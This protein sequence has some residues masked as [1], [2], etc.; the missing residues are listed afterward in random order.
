MRSTTLGYGSRK[1]RKL[2]AKMLAVTAG[3][4]DS[5][6]NFSAARNCFSDDGVTQV[7]PG[8]AVY[9]ANETE[10]AA[11]FAQ[12]VLAARPLFSPALGLQFDGIDDLMEGTGSLLTVAQAANAI[13][14]FGRINFGTLAAAR[15]LVVLSHNGSGNRF[16]FRVLTTGAL[17]FSLRRLDADSPMSFTT[18]SG[19]VA[20]NT[21]YSIIASVD[22]VGNTASIYL[23]GGSDIL[24]ATL[25]LA[26]PAGPTSNTASLRARL[27]ASVAGVPID[28]FDGTIVKAGVIKR[29][30]SAEERSVIFEY[31]ANNMI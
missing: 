8:A 16:S 9:R 30:P 1:N 13:T 23:N 12:T 17:Q 24:G 22:Y 18:A 20:A 3:G 7:T 21:T 27:G 19:V 31:L 6:F 15:Q 26:S 11:T 10:G 28:F 14:F 25:T 5:F 4:E 2:L 29:V